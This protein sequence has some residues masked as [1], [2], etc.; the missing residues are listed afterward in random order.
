VEVGT[1]EVGVEAG[2]SAGVAQTATRLIRRAA[3]A[4]LIAPFATG[5]DKFQTEGPRTLARPSLFL[6]VIYEINLPAA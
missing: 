5:S 3:S 6:I 2:I 1:A 4:I